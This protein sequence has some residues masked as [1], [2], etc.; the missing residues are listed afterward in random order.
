M[1]A[2][3][4]V[5]ADWIVSRGGVASGDAMIG[6]RLILE[7]IDKHG[8]SRFQTAPVDVGDRMIVHSRMGFREDM[9]V[10]D[11][12]GGAIT[13]YRYWMDEAAFNEIIGKRDPKAV[14]D[15]MAERGLLWKE[16]SRFTRKTPGALDPD[17][18]RRLC[19]VPAGREQEATTGTDELPR[20]PASQSPAAT[21]H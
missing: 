11:Q 18:K 8:H 13:G 17:R 12:R 5:Y 2:V 7:A 4:A 15:H 16:G 3:K 9:R 20:A 10:N 19:I 21:V 1:E 14:L 6:T